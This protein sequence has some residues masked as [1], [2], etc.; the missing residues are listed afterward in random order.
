M[1]GAIDNSY[2][3]LMD[4]NVAGKAIRKLRRVLIYGTCVR[5]EHPK[6]YESI[7]QNRVPLAVCLEREHFNI[8]ALKVASMLARVKLEE[9]VVLTVDGSPHCV[10]LHM[11]IEEALKV[12]KSNIPVKH[13]VIENGEVIEIPPHCVKIAR[14]LSKIKK[15]QEKLKNVER[16]EL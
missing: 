10:Q 16:R 14:Y 15:L 9:L 6:I 11:A 8:V 13:L 2:K 1:R 5:H 4:H 3:D 7:S 12:T